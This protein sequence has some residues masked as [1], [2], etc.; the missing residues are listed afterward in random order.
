MADIP[1]LLSS[2]VDRDLLLQQALADSARDLS[3]DERYILRRLASVV[4]RHRPETTKFA[5]VLVS[6]PVGEFAAHAGLTLKV[7]LRRLDV[8]THSLFNRR[9]RLLSDDVDTSIAWVG[10]RREAAAYFALTFT[11]FF[12]EH[13]FSIL[14][15][16][17]REEIVG[18]VEFAGGV[19]GPATL[20]RGSTAPHG[21]PI[22]LTSRLKARGRRPKGMSMTHLLKRVA[23]R[24]KGHIDKDRLDDILDVV[25][26]DS[27]WRGMDNSKY[28]KFSH[29]D[30]YDMQKWI[31]M[32]M[33]E[34]GFF[35]Y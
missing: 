35:S 24:L 34:P 1:L 28:Y 32:K 12:V 15:P 3:A 9:V 27:P 14:R 30:L 25:I 21:L 11:G 19:T 13:L 16:D 7:A 17:W 8:A 6:L 10:T 23:K 20:C 5:D 2:R 22:M 33:K 31:F 26:Q 4:A 18:V 29:R